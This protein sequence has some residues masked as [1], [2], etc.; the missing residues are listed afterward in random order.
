[1]FWRFL[2]YFSLVSIHCII[3]HFYENNNSETNPIKITNIGVTAYFITIISTSRLSDTII[4]Y[5]IGIRT[6]YVTPITTTILRRT[7]S[8]VSSVICLSSTVTISY[9]SKIFVVE[10]LKKSTL[11]LHPNICRAPVCGWMIYYLQK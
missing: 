7:T 11:E 5:T 1:M 10:F 2:F 3:H 8:T 9:K 4:V 6:I